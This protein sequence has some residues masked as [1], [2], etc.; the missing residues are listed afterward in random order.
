M[1]YMDHVSICF[2]CLVWFV[3]DSVL[4]LNWSSPVHTFV[5]DNNDRFDLQS[6]VLCQRS[7]HCAVLR[8][9]YSNVFWF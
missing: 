6:T 5:I 8:T 4:L 7:L 1:V 2:S 3:H 9:S